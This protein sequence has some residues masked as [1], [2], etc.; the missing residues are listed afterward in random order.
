MKHI[1]FYTFPD[2]EEENGTENACLVTV[3]KKN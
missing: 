1:A 2:P 3:S